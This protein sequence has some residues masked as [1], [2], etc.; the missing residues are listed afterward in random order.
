MQNDNRATLRTVWLRLVL[1]RTTQV[2]V[3]SQDKQEEDKYR[4]ADG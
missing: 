2:E 1:R 3:Q 4:N